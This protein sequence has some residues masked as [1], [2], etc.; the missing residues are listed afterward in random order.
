MEYRTITSL[1]KQIEYQGYEHKCWTIYIHLLSL[2][3]IVVTLAILLI[4]ILLTEVG[5]S[6]C[7]TS[8]WRIA[9]KFV[10]VSVSLFFFSSMQCSMY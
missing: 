9:M 4:Y 5:A 10:S 6:A 8:G 1:P 7:C 2:N 3:A